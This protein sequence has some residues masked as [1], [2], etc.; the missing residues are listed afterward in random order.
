MKW[1]SKAFKAYFSLSLIGFIFLFISCSPKQQNS[2]TLAFYHWKS[3]L[4]L[5][6]QELSYLEELQIKKLYVRFFDLDI[7]NQQSVP[8]SVLTS[9]TKIPDSIAIIPTV[10][11]TNRTLLN[12]EL[13]SIPD[14]SD[15]IFKK[16]N[17]LSENF[18][19]NPI[20]EVQFDCDWSPD[21][22]EKYFQLLQLL[23]SKFAVQNT[24]L[25]AT[26]RL[27]QI[28][29]FETTG[30]PDVDRGVLMLYNMSPIDNIKTRNSILDISVARQYL[31][32]FEKYPL[33]LDIA[34]PIF[35]W[36]LIFQEDKLVKIINNLDESDLSDTGRFL[37]LDENRFEILKSTYLNGY[38]LYKSDQIRLEKVQVSDLQQAAALLSPLLNNQNRNII[39]YHLDSTLIADFPHEALK[40]IYTRFY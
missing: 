19:N 27:H 28:K 38:Y 30:V 36:G 9:I 33:P 31:I 8:V 17:Q 39:F 37:K 13:S 6:N 20:D 12:I 10:F 25:S 40:D 26:I 16:I 5:S 3:S 15:K 23:N 21:T 1:F 32:N 11:I 29:Y 35:K 4:N 2:V 22:Q 18:V 34:L 14:L 7:E 24:K